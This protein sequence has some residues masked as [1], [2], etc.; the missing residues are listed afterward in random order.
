MSKDECILVDEADNVT[1][2][3]NKY[4]SH[5]WGVQAAVQ[6]FRGCTYA[7]GARVGVGPAAPSALMCCTRL[8]SPQTPPQHGP[9]VPAVA[10]LAL[11]PHPCAQV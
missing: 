6:H 11:K 3:A 7:G 1:G 5:R 2:H 9:T 10:D 8:P 4:K